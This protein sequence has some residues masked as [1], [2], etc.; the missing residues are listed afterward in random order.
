V[1]SWATDLD[2]EQ[3]PPFPTM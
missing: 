1:K 2:P 3:T